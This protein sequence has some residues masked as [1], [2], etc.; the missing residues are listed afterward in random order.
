MDYEWDP[1]KAKS[2]AKKHGVAF[3]DAAIA[4]EDELAITIP[5]PD[6]RDEERF[7]S[8]GADATGRILVTVFSLREDVVRIISSR[9]SSTGER[10]HYEGVE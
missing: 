2:N 6:L 10:K 8:I 9:N 7:V 4:L 3:S 1:V 5:D